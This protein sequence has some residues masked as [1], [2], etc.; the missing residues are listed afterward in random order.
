MMVEARHSSGSLCSGILELWIRNA[1]SSLLSVGICLISVGI[2]GYLPVWYLS[3]SV[4][5]LRVSAWYLRVCICL[6]SVGICLVS[7]LSGLCFL[8]LFCPARPGGPLPCLFFPYLSCPGA[9]RPFLCYFFFARRVPARP[10]LASSFLLALSLPGASWCIP[11]SPFLGS[12]SL[13]PG[14]PGAV[15]GPHHG[16]G[17]DTGHE[18]I[19]T[20]IH[21]IHC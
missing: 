5:Y 15:P 16:G 2:C 19:Y 17:V 10:F 13:C 6:V 11:S 1:P 12:F 3:V 9:S 4:W 20:Y 18:S 14:R 21:L 7:A 8:S